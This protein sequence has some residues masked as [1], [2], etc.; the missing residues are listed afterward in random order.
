MTDTARLALPL[1]MA[2]QAQKE[3]TV[4][5]TLARLDIAVQAS[6][7]E[8]GRDVPP[9]SPHEGETWIVGSTP[10]GAWH[11]RAGALAGWT[12][13]GW[14]FLTPSDGWRVWSIADGCA[15]VHRGG[16]WRLSV[17]PGPR[18]AAIPNPIGGAVTDGE[19]R[20]AIIAVL[21]ALRG[22]GLIQN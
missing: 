18:A 19:A 12:A 6:A 8:V 22:H 16:T 1:L 3:M 11:G 9:T 14:R 13:G 5:E 17:A 20:A 2:G 21:D 4:N 10:A 7:V 15:V